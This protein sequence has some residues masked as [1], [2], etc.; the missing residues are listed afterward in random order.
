MIFV[1]K[2]Y[3]QEHV[4]NHFEV[5]SVEML[6]CAKHADVSDANFKAII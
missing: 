4:S 6:D 5:R 1:I 3:Q 2:A